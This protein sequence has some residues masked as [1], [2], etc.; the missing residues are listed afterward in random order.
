MKVNNDIAES[1]WVN[2]QT[3]ILTYLG[4][5][6]LHYKVQ[7]DLKMRLNSFHQTKRL[8]IPL[9]QF[10]WEVDQLVLHYMIPDRYHLQIPSVFLLHNRI[11]W[12]DTRYSA[13]TIEQV[14]VT[15]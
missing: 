11:Q 1:K 2:N 7:I 6:R 10:S 5:Q 14:I 15:T 8:R 9:Y 12:S 4:N 3:K 13:K